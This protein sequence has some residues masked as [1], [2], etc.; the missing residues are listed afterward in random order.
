MFPLED[1]RKGIRLN[2][3]IRCNYESFRDQSH[4]RLNLIVD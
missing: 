2:G 4:G 3:I 1:N